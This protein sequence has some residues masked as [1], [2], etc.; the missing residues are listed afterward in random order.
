M[1]KSCHV[2]FNEDDEEIT[3]SSIKGKEI[4]FNENRSF[5]DD[6]FLIPRS[7][8]SQG[9]GKDDLFPYFSIDDDHLVEP[10]NSKRANDFEPGE[11]FIGVSEPQNITISEGEPLPKNI[12]P[13]TEVFINLYVPQ[14][15]WSREKHIDLVNILGE[16]QASVTTRSRIRDS[17]AALTHECLYVNFISEIKPKKLIEALEE[18][19][20]IIAMQKELNQFERN[21]VWILVLCLMG[22]RQ[23]E[24][25]DYDETFAHI[26]RL[27]AIRIF[28]AYVAY[29]V[30]HMDVKSA[31]LNR[32]ISEEVYVQQP[33]RFESSEFP[34]HVCKLDKVLY[35]QKQASK[36]C[37]L[38]KCPMLPPNNLGPDESGVSVNET[39]YQA[40]PKESHLV[41]VKSIFRYL[42]GTPNLDL[43]VG[44]QRSKAMLPC[45][46]LKLY[47]LLLNA[48]L[49]V[50]DP[51]LW[52]VND[53]DT[54]D[55]SLFGTSVK[56]VNQPKAPT[57]KNSKKKKNPASS[58]PKTSKIVRKSSPIIQVADTQHAEEPVATADSTKSINASK[59]EVV[60]EHVITSLG[61]VTFKDLYGHAEENPFD[62]EYSYSCSNTSEHAKELSMFDEADEDESEHAKELSVADEATA[63]NMIDEL[64]DKAHTQDDNLNISA[65]IETDS[66]LLLSK[67]LGTSWL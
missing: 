67:C 1:E 45:H 48:E 58:K 27:E 40:N 8:V 43:Y 59:K 52:G 47:T 19:G 65:T 50:F 20:W 26:T 35:G 42:K 14:D 38:V 31:F 12:S 39:L 22:F 41:A 55:N 53:D 9:T 25:I 30:Y 29:M 13:S 16:P 61:N 10:D 32:K 18:E 4:N 57:N 21:N 60:N 46:Q 51:S 33:P 37:T 15:R 24:G 28:L 23:E 6:E 2:T 54:T 66:H 64:V 44:V 11:T 56:P 62:T 5:P 49:R 63:D 34:N 17:E 36:A 3:Q 7:K